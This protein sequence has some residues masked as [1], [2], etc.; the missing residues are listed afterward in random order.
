MVYAVVERCP[1][2]GG[3]VASF[4]STRAKAVP[5]VKDV[6][7][8]SSGLAV[9]ADNTWSAMQG[10]RALDVQWDEGQGASLNSAGISATLAQRN[11]EEG[12]EARKDGDP[13]SS[14]TAGHLKQSKPPAKFF[15]CRTL[16]WSQ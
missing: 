5:G 15:T 4:D 16:R 3:K 6:V 2:F 12:A 10:R 8:I 13:G 7:Q 14:Q 1:V 11:K 9:V